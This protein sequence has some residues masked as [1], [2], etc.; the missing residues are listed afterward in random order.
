M[1]TQIP[2]FFTQ[3]QRLW[4]VIFLFV[5]AFGLRLYHINE[6]SLNFHVLRQ[7]HSAII[8]RGYYFERLDSIPEWRKI[9]AVKNKQNMAILEPRIIEWIA[10]LGYQIFGRENL[11]IPQ[12]MSSLFWVIGGI[13]LYLI[14]GKITFTDAA[15]CATAFYL[16][17]PFGVTASMSFLPDILMLMMLL[18]SIFVI[19]CYYEQPSGCKLFLATLTAAVAIFI[20]P[21]CIFLIFGSFISLAISQQGLRRSVRHQDFWIFVLI[22]LSLAVLYYF[23]YGVFIVGFV[24]GQVQLNQLG[25][26][27]GS[28]FWKAWFTMIWRTVGYV[29]II[30]S[31]FGLL[32]I[33]SGLP[34]A[35]LFGLWIGYFIFG[36]VFNFKV[37]S[38]DYY[39]I[40]IIPIVALSLGP[41]GALIFNS[42]RQACTVRHCRIIIFEILLLAVILGMYQARLRIL[43]PDFKVE[44]ARIAKDI[45]EIVNHS[46]GTIFLTSQS[47][48]LL[49]SRI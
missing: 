46:T 1:L 39:Q 48:K 6:L 28:F 32:V 5:A 21:I 43:D 47:G 41:V 4:V 37:S 24:K 40:Q 18:V 42:L 11:R 45:G 49:Q 29:A 7:H 12:I 34:R 23:F 33:H 13:F 22:S 2:S 30:G 15:L 10:S 26:L 17:L 44:E 35:L 27:G 31:L 38:F 20:K 25:L 9:T 19:L 16:F 3:K 8:A 14:A 36:L